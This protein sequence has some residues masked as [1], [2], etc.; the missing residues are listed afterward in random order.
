MWNPW[1]VQR[2]R[3]QRLLV[4]L[5]RIVE[6]QSAAVTALATVA[7]K[8]LASFQVE[9]LPRSWVNTDA[10]EAAAER[11]RLLNE[12]EPLAPLDGERARLA[13]IL[14]ELDG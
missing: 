4:A 11:E 5:E 14:N 7:E 1:K 12:P 13:F 2:E 10:S 6:A 8:Y 3:E 9:G